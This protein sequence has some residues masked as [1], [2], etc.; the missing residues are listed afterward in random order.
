[1]FAKYAGQWYSIVRLG[2]NLTERP[3]LVKADCEHAS[4]AL[5]A[6]QLARFV[7]EEEEHPVD[8]LAE[9]LAGTAFS[10][11]IVEPIA[12]NPIEVTG[13]ISVRAAIMQLVAACGGNIAYDGLSIHI[14]NHRGSEIVRTLTD[15][16]ITSLSV[17]YEDRLDNADGPAGSYE[18]ELYRPQNLSV[19]DE[20]RIVSTSAGLDVHTRIIGMSYN[21]FDRRFVKVDVGQF[22]PEWSVP[23]GAL[24]DL[25]GR[26]ED[27]EKMTAKYTA[28]FG[29]ITGS[30]IL[31]FRIGYIDKPTYFIRSEGGMPT[32]ELL[33]SEDLYIGASVSNPDAEAVTSL[34][35]Y[36]T[37]PNV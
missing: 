22:M 34:L 7:V 30:G 32:V 29:N 13:K 18:I 20:V 27:I 28:E 11:G 6:I 17:T 8:V 36:C 33:K 4:F 10:V 12:T 15:E 26:V 21:P 37:L 19:G 16:G 5:N 1:M 3:R 25:N 2:M 14:L 24:D 9:L 35:F 31:Y 23:Q